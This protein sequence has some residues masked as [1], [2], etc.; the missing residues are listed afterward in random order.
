VHPDEYE[1]PGVKLDLTKYQ[2]T[3]AVPDP[4]A[5]AV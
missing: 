1:M 5:A 2:T 3:P 4:E